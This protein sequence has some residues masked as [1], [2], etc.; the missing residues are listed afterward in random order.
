[1]TVQ[2]THAQTRQR[3]RVTVSGDGMS[4]TL[5]LFRPS[6]GE[7][8]ISFDEIVE[9][10]HITGIVHG[11]DEGAARRCL[12]QENF[13][14]P[15]TIAT[16]TKPVKGSNSTFSYHFDTSND[17]TPKEDD[18]G[19]IDY[20]SIDFI[21][22][23]DKDAVLVTKTP[24]TPGV[25][26]KTVT[27]KEIKAPSGRDIPFDKG[28]NTAVSE[29]GL[30]LLATAGGA[31]VYR[32]GKVAVSDLTT[33]RGDV[34]HT[35]GNINTKGSVRV[36]GHIKAGFK[37]DV[38]GDLE[39]GGNVEDVEASAGGNISVKGGFFGKSDG[40]MT[41]GGDITVKF[42]EGQRLQAQGSVLVGGEIIN[43]QVYARDKVVVKGRN[44]KIIGGDVKAGKQ[45]RAGKLGSDAGTATHLHVAYD[46]E[47]MKQYAHT[48]GEIDRLKADGERVKEALVSLYKLQL[49]GQLPPA[50]QKALEELKQFKDDLPATIEL[51]EQRKRAIE[52]K[53]QEYAGAQ[54]IAEDMIYP[55]V[56]A[57][58]GM[59][60]RE[61]VDEQAKCKLTIDGTRISISEFHDSDGRQ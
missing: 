10:V 61:I 19:R 34:D 21:I 17:H 48:Q 54:I 40:V 30:S 8:A 15:V 37:V 3:V 46:P 45:I 57:H 22:S 13:N 52:E 24:P 27:G 41:A 16:G 23:T 49:A 53:L 28:E 9:Q 47:L 33:I 20:R 18:D 60:Y 36:T 1:V 31:I 12:E 38:Q 51:L 11:F 5:I 58:F 2:E 25:P 59:V 42:A 14:N 39:V 50:K 26:G 43:C 44:S 55:G 56:V 32:Y 4:A 7:S 35:V 6:A 29:D